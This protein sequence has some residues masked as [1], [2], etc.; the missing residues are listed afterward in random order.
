MLFTTVQ[1]SSTAY[2]GF[3][4]SACRKNLHN[5]V[6][7]FSCT[8]EITFDP[9]TEKPRPASS[10]FLIKQLKLISRDF[11]ITMILMSILAP[12]GWELFDTRQEVN[13]L[14]HSL[15]DL[16]SWQHLANNYLVASKSTAWFQML[17]KYVCCISAYILV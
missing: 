14:G 8:F 4:P 7:Y 16:F 15:Q 11:G 5:F 1:T 10:T 3:T 12:F 2:F 9:M 13:S 17:V 6:I